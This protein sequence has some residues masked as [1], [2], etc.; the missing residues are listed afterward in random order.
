MLTINRA[1]PNC[2][3]YYNSFNS[4]HNPF[5]IGTAINLSGRLIPKFPSPMISASL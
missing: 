1:L 3:I 5:E 4:R 2:F